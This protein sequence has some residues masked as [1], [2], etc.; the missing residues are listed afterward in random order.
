MHLIAFAIIIGALAA[1]L[2]SLLGSGVVSSW[3]PH[4]KP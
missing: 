4:S 1:L 3:F 2:G